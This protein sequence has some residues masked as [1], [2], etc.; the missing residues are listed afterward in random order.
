MKLKIEFRCCT[1]AGCG[2]HVRIDAGTAVAQAV[3]IV[4]AAAVEGW[5][6]FLAIR[7]SMQ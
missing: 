3:H 6:C 4:A 5:S 1:C 2:G 7:R